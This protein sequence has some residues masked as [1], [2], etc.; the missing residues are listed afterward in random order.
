MGY[1]LAEDI[2]MKVL[3]LN[4][5]PHG[6]G[7]TYTALAE[8]ASTLAE[9]GIETEI[10]QLGTKALNGCTACLKCRTLGK[11]ALGET[12]GVNDFLEKASKADGFVF[13]APVHYASAAGAVKAFMDRLFYAEGNSGQGRFYLKPAA[14]VIAARR[15]GTTAAFDQMNKYF[16]VSSMPVISSQYWNMVHGANGEDAKKDLEGM[17]TMRTLARNMAWF[18]RCKEAGE[19]AGVARPKLEERVRT[20]F[21]GPERI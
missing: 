16:T 10:V 14:A 6:A 19:R 18:L 3:L 5:S 17:Q 2:G 21:I 7:T 4:G 9:E 1:T 15:G 11:C 8:V 13:G 20:N 12:D